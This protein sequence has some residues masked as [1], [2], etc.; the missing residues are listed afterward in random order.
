M[1]VIEYFKLNI[2]TLRYTI[3]NGLNKIFQAFLQIFAI[4]VIT[5]L[6]NNN[7]VTILFLLFG[8]IVW[9]QLFE[10][11][12][13]QTLQNK[14]NSKEISSSNF[15][16]ICIIH[17]TVLFF[18]SVIFYMTSAYTFLLPNENFNKDIIN[19]F[20]LG[21]SILIVSCNNLV[22]QRLLM[23]LNADM[24]INKFQ[25]LQSLLSVLGLSFCLLNEE[26][27]LYIVILSYFLPFLIINLLTL[28]KVKKLFNLKLQFSKKIFKTNFFSHLLYF[29][30]IGA[31]SSIYVGLDYYFATRF[32][33]ISEINEY[34]IYSRVFFISFIFYYS[35]IQYSSKNISKNYLIKN[36]ENIM[37]ISK[38]SIMIGF[39]A[40]FGI[41][42]I[43]IIMN[44]HGIII[45]LTNGIS[46]KISIL[47]FALFYYI[48]RVFRDV[49]LIILRCTDFV[50]KSIIIHLI[51]IFV[52]I[53]LMNYFIPK[54]QIN[55]LFLS[56][57]I[58]TVCGLLFFIKDFR[59][60]KL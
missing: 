14:Y 15:Y 49:I 10:A 33:K 4:F 28:I 11:G 44:N 31:L 51:E 13:S 20:S 59:K 43:T 25:F 36:Y 22:I 47:Y 17:L 12:F 34:H 24:L 23:V 7:E 53:L 18:L 30:I 8:Y 5:K 45:W 46:L 32:L 54:Y 2:I 9:F 42:L 26:K 6:F 21:C 29:W 35:F 56:Y 37:K 41:F 19:S 60:L 16:F 27:N 48:V 58:A 57:S 55:G 1:K 39:F 50:K 38:V 52:A 3:L 40:V